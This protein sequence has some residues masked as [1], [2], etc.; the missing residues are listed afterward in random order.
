MRTLVF[1]FESIAVLAAAL[2]DA[3]GS[4]L[5]VPEGESVNDGEW[6]LATFEIGS[7]RR[8]TASAA[9]GV[10]AAGA[11]P[12]L[13]FER[14]DWERLQGFVNARS[15]HLRAARPVVDLGGSASSGKM[16]VDDEFPPSSTGM[17]ST[18]NPIQAR[19]LLVDDDDDDTGRE[20]LRA[21]LSEIG[22]TVEVVQSPSA[23]EQRMREQAFDAV[24]IDFEESGKD[25]LAFI[26]ALRNNPGLSLL[27]VLVLSDRP[28][29]RDV[30]DAFASGA[31]DFLPRP[32]R[33][34]ELG[35][36]IFGLLRRARFAARSVPPTS[37]G[38]GE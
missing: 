18:R 29:S 21:M 30:V 26:R 31:D 4:S 10:V 12:R 5:Q 27:P 35:A 34:P 33:A 17:E 36:R 11:P 2:D 16:R 25:P 8:A 1:R 3:G 37:R 22:L 6:V 23:A 9:R 15:E 14:R 38:G 7:R 20:Q 28:S 19:V 32:F 24:V 13:T